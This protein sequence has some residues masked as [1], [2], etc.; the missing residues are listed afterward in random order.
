MELLYTC[1]NC[2][3]SELKELEYIVENMEEIP[4]DSFA[5]NI[6]EFELNV[7]LEEL[8][9]SAAFPIQKDWAVR[10]YQCMV[11]RKLRFILVHSAIEYVF[12]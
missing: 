9:Y 11:K 6:D 5:K 10:F 2:N 7:L 4:F 1:V 8:G 3:D 12:G